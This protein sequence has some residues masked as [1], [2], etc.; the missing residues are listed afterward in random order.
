MSCPGR[1]PERRCPSCG[2][3]VHAS[4]FHVQEKLTTFYVGESVLGWDKANKAG[5]MVH[6]FHSLA[7]YGLWFISLLIDQL[8]PLRLHSD[9]LRKSHELPRLSVPGLTF[10]RRRSLHKAQAALRSFSGHATAGS[11]CLSL[12]IRWKLQRPAEHCWM[13][14]WTGVGTTTL[15]ALATPASAAAAISAASE[16]SPDG[17]LYWPALPPLAHLCHGH[18]KALWRL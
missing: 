4:A 3:L 16:C 6:V 14:L 1:K 17:P 18:S 12:L 7:F 9:D 8:S 10:L 2:C 13:R 15:V 11:K 5:N